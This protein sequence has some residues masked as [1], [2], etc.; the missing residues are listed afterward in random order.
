MSIEQFR[1]AVEE[2]ELTSLDKAKI[3]GL[4]RRAIRVELEAGVSE[5]SPGTSRFGGRPDLPPAMSWPVFGDRPM[6]FLVQICL[7]ELPPASAV[8]ERAWLPS[9]GRLYF[10]VGVPRTDGASTPN[11]SPDDVAAFSVLF[12]DALADALIRTANPSTSEAELPVAGLRFSTVLI[13]PHPD[14]PAVLALLNSDES[15]LR[16]RELHRDPALDPI[17]RE[18]SPQR[19]LGYP[20]LHSNCQEPTGDRPEPGDES[21]HATS[22]ELLLQL[23]SPLAPGAKTDDGDSSK[24]RL[25]FLIRKDDLLAKRWDRIWLTHATAG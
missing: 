4:P 24:G 13:F 20:A 6:T 8:P 9:H 2:S 15:R 22:C 21:D 23:D 1:K 10:F 14:E 25:V 12:S 18:S 11:R 3:V 16:Y 7:D 19:M 5:V 17:V